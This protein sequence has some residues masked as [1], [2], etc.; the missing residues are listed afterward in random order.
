M[1][2]FKKISERSMP[3]SLRQVS[4]SSRIP[5]KFGQIRASAAKLKK[6]FKDTSIGGEDFDFPI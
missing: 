3:S 6:D 2:D 5:Y 4:S 1:K